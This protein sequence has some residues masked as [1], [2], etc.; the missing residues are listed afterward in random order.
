MSNKSF[1]TLLAI[2]FFGFIILW[3]IHLNAGDMVLSASDNA[4]LIIG[5]TGGVDPKLR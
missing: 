1:L 4:S 3:F 2:I 5:A